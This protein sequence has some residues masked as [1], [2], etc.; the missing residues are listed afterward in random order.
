MKPEYGHLHEK[1]M[2]SSHIQKGQNEGSAKQANYKGM[3]FFNS[4]E[5]GLRFLVFWID[6]DGSFEIFGCKIKLMH[7]LVGLGTTLENM[8]FVWLERQSSLQETNMETKGNENAA[9]KNP[10]GRNKEHREKHQQLRDA[11]QDR[12]I[13]FP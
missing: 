7:R 6:F 1:E 5:Q 11:D 10:K 13:Q 2:N 4:L 9:V 12:P 3:Q 8:G